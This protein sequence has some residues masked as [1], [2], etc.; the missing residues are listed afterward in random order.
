MNGS[1]L[2]ESSLYL[3]GGILAQPLWNKRP[4]FPSHRS[5]SSLPSTI[6][7]WQTPQGTLPRRGGFLSIGMGEFFF[8]FFFFKQLWLTH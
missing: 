4:R 1:S 7:P 8:F 2:F 6:A 3:H 5:T